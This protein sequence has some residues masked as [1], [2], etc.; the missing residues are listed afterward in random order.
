MILIR[1]KDVLK[2]KMLTIRYSNTRYN[3]DTQ[4]IDSDFLKS[5]VSIDECKEVELSL[6]E[7]ILQCIITENDIELLSLNREY[8]FKGLNYFGSNTMMSKFLDGIKMEVYSREKINVQRDIENFLEENSTD[9]EFRLIGSNEAVSFDFIQKN[10]HRIDIENTATNTSI[11]ESFF[12]KHIDKFT[13]EGEGLSGLCQNTSLNGEFFERHYNEDWE[14][15]WGIISSNDSIT[16]EYIESHM[17]Y[18]WDWGYLSQR[19][20]SIAF[21]KRHIDK[22]SWYALSQNSHLPISFFEEYIDRVD[23]ETIWTNTSITESFIEKYI[24]RVDWSILCGNSS[25][26]E[27][28]FEKYIDRVDWWS[29]G[30]NS[31]LSRCFLEKYIDRFESWIDLSSWCKYEDFLE[32]HFNRVKWGILSSCNKNLSEKFI[33]DN[34][35]KLNRDTFIGRSFSLSF[36]KRYLEFF[37]VNCINLCLCNF[38]VDSEVKGRINSTKYYSFDKMWKSI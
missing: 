16:E 34:I 7:D 22:V 3:I 18:T 20:F 21:F 15:I 29:M 27:S 4:S 9:E 37:I 8:V 28:F 31:S 26:S 10:I 2:S 33:G 36:Y 35:I 1:H 19:K 30:A 6:F 23:W 13:W 17:D 11:P 5:I 14:G 38:N 25:V 32:K 24:D 12:D